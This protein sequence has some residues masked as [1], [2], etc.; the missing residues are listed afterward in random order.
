MK[1]IDPTSVENHKPQWMIDRAK[2]KLYGDDA[3][4]FNY[5]S[6]KDPRAFWGFSSLRAFADFVGNLEKPIPDKARGI[7]AMAWSE[8]QEFCD[9]TGVASLNE[10]VRLARDGWTDGLGLSGVMLT[11]KPVGK[12]RSHGVA[13]GSVNVGRMLAGN[14][15]H[16]RRRTPAPGKRSIT[17]FVDCCMWRGITAL[18]A[19]MR[20]L[21]IVSIIDA[22]EAEGYRCA[23]VAI[24]VDISSSN[25]KPKAQF[26]VRIKETSDRLNLLDISFALGH[27][28]F[29]RRMCFACEGVAIET[30]ITRDDRN[31]LSE[32]F[33]EGCKD[34]EF[35]IGRIMSNEWENDPLGMLSAI[36]PEGLP[37][38]VKERVY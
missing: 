32:P 36:E 34:G 27:P 10:A 31:L 33:A 13:G 16:M 18:S 9:H 12:R 8:S 35:Y 23:V 11:P 25:H 22:L 7:S 2:T 26:A 6:D 4:Y 14:P 21:V 37:I 30:F 29:L 3:T 28:A 17:L 19:M 15:S 38:S 5:F 20:A 1:I 24:S